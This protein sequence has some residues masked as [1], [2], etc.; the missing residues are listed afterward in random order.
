MNTSSKG[1]AIKLSQHA[2]ESVGSLS[3]VN[4]NEVVVEEG[5]RLE[6]ADLDKNEET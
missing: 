2:N 4:G 5:F 6:E 1:K 3:E